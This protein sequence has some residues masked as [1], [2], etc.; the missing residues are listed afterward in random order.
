MTDGDRCYIFI[1]CPQTR[2]AII[3]NIIS[4]ARI[5]NSIFLYFTLIFGRINDK[6]IKKIKKA[7]YNKLWLDFPKMG[8]INAQLIITPNEIIKGGYILSN[9]L[10]FI[11]IYSTIL[12]I[13]PIM[14]HVHQQCTGDKAAMIIYRWHSNTFL[15]ST[16]VWNINGFIVYAR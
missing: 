15:A 8:Q 2:K 3:N 6:I 10:F 7:P 12:F 5:A 13:L 14:R 9:R 1:F 16:G 11:Y 4:N